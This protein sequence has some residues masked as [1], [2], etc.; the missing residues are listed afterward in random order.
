MIRNKSVLKELYQILPIPIDRDKYQCLT[1]STHDFELNLPPAGRH[2]TWHHR[3]TRQ[4]VETGMSC[5]HGCEDDQTCK[6]LHSHRKYLHQISFLPRRPGSYIRC[7]CSTWSC[8][9]ECRQAARWCRCRRHCP[10]SCRGILVM[11]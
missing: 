10:G 11:L 7:P 8:G 4:V 2:T 3:N 9:F 1:S 6:F 5:H